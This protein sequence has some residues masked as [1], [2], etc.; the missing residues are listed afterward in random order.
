MVKKCDLSRTRILPKDN[1]KV[2][3]AALTK[4]RPDGGL[5]SY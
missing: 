3:G 4:T 5:F 1:Y 2:A